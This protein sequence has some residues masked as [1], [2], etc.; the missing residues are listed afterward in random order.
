MPNS[1]VSSGSVVLIAPAS[2]IASIAGPFSSIVQR[3]DQ[4]NPDDQR[5]PRATNITIAAIGP[6]TVKVPIR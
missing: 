5:N 1:A 2:I 4:S 6:T 3:D